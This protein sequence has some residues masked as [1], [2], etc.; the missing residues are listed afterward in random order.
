V[1][2]EKCGG[3][4][5][6]SEGLVRGRRFLHP[7]LDFTFTAPAHDRAGDRGAQPRRL[8]VVE[9][10]RGDTVERL[11]RHMALSDRAA[12]RFRSQRAR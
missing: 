4:G 8:K 2:A 3:G 6:L 11:A 5:D 7:K 10:K 1:T 12:E 9:V